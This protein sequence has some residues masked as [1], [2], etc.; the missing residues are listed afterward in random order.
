V[1]FNSLIGLNRQ[2]ATTTAITLTALL[3][4]GPGF[5]TA[6]TNSDAP[7]S[8]WLIDKVD[9]SEP[10]KPGTSVI[11][12]N[13]HG[14]VRVRAIKDAQDN[15]LPL[16]GIIQRHAEDEAVP[17]IR[18]SPGDPTVISVMYADASDPYS[19]EET[20]NRRTRRVDLAVFVPQ[21]SSIRVVT[22]SGLIKVK[23]VKTSVQARSVSGRIWISS[24]GS[25]DAR[26]AH[27]DVGVVVKKSGW[28]G[29]A[30][31][32]TTT[33]AAAIRLPREINAIVNIETGGM[34]TTDYSLRIRRAATSHTKRARTKIYHGVRRFLRILPLGRNR[35][36]LRSRT[37]DIML[38]RPNPEL[39]QS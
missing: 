26:S 39:T 29:D 37:G 13:L 15:R 32:E 19:R 10:I 17:D 38:I 34:I 2:V 6:A 24:S 5:V 12:S 11:V 1:F 33:G 35:I 9:M 23:G 21:K 16:T 18:Y 27:G 22:D 20:T 28:R 8:D 31:I 30:T 25:I 3:C 36:K 7:P 14:D 4:I